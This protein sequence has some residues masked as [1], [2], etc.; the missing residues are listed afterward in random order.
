MPGSRHRDELVERTLEGVQDAQ[1]R[2]DGAS[3][4]RR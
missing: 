4:A 2:I 3:G 1:G